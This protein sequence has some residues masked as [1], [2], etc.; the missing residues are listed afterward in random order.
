MEF[1]L[2]LLIG[3]TLL[4]ALVGSAQSQ[5]I[6]KW[7][8]PD[9]TLYFGDKPPAGSMKIGEEGSNGS[10]SNG[11]PQESAPR[12]AEQERLSICRFSKVLDPGFSKAFPPGSSGRVT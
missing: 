6:Q 5:T 11:S 3:A 4:G 9:G 7:K 10:P 12:S 8:T 1:Q 2:W